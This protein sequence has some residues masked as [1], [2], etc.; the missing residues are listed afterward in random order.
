MSPSLIV[1]QI[2][3]SFRL[4]YHSIW[5][6]QERSKLGKEVCWWQFHYE[7]DASAILKFNWEV[8][9]WVEEVSRVVGR[10]SSIFL[11]EESW[12]IGQKLRRFRARCL[13]GNPARIHVFY[14][15]N[16]YTFGK[17]NVFAFIS[18]LFGLNMPKDEASTIICQKLFLSFAFIA[19]KFNY[20]LCFHELN[21][22]SL[23]CGCALFFVLGPVVWAPQSQSF[24]CLMLMSTETLAELLLKSAW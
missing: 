13:R 17:L 3:L 24:S 14:F 12:A 22:P 15:N 6:H 1:I 2:F 8:W 18:A 5:L 23:R 11:S 20:C 21:I 16:R 9:K 19:T 4:D 7:N 10:E